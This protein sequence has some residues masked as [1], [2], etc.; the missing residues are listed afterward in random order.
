MS[1]KSWIY[2]DAKKAAAEIQGFIDA[3]VTHV[4]MIDIIPSLLE[5]E[6]SSKAI[7]RSIDVCRYVKAANS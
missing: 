3:G 6:E 2:G 7:S 4:A 1:H 5:P